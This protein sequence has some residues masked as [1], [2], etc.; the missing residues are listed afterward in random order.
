MSTL[1]LRELEGDLLARGPL[2][3]CPEKGCKELFRLKK[4]W[5]A[6]MRRVHGKIKTW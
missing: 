2:K 1:S 3:Q 6:H 5:Q 4:R